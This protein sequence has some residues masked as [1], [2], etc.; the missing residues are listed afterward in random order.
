MKIEKAAQLISVM[1]SFIAT[2]SVDGHLVMKFL[3]V[4]RDITMRQEFLELYKLSR[5]EEHGLIADCYRNEDL[6]IIVQY[7][8]PFP[9][10]RYQGLREFLLNRKL[11]PVSLP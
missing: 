3:A 2:R 10:L 4:P 6:S 11:S 9:E 1:S 5:W 7:A 8:A